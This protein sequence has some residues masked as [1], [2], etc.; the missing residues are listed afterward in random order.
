MTATCEHKSCQ[1]TFKTPS[2]LERHYDAVHSTESLAAKEITI[3][4]NRSV[5]RKVFKSC[6]PDSARKKQAVNDP[7]S[8]P[9]YSLSPPEKSNQEESQS[10]RLFKIPLVPVEEDSV[11]KNSKE[12]GK[13]TRKE[14]ELPKY[15]GSLNALEQMLAEFAFD[16]ELSNSEYESFVKIVQAGMSMTHTAKKTIEIKTTTLDKLKSTLKKDADPCSLVEFITCPI[17]VHAID[18]F[19]KGHEKEFTEGIVE[20]LELVYRD[21]HDLCEHLFSHPSFSEVMN[22]YPSIYR[23]DDDVNGP[24]VYGDIDSG[25][26]WQSLQAELSD[27]YVLLPIMLASDQ[28]TVSGNFRTKAW[29]VYMK[30]GNIPVEARDQP[31][32]RASRLLAYFPTIDWKATTNVPSWFTTAKYAVIHYCLSKILGRFCN[33]ADKV[34]AFRMNGPGNKQYKCI[35][36]LACYIADLP[37]QR[38][39]ALVKGGSSNFSCPRC[40]VGTCSFH[41]QYEFS[42]DQGKSVGRTKKYMKKLYEKGK[43][44]GK[45]ESLKHGQ[46]HSYHLVEVSEHRNTMC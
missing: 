32:Y 7:R 19:P 33:T 37:E 15:P 1:K 22:I 6:D 8:T 26:W 39:L 34:Q 40:K 44:L 36:A 28:T 29:P 12:D 17:D 2:A 43:S 35:P 9:L 5:K 16:T 45:S 46:R 18:D 27:E 11:I 24:R 20:P 25:N 4:P 41:C 38:M 13:T 30:L 3:R 23:R 21:M 42:F 10:S 31:C 14:A